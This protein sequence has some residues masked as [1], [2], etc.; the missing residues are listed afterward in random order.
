MK[1][2]EN[3]CQVINTHFNLKVRPLQVDVVIDIIKYKRDI[4]AIIGTNIGKSFVNQTIPVVIEE[5]I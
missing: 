5:F 4:Y 1:K 3:I 2:V